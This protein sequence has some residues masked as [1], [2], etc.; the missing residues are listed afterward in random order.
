M[1]TIYPATYYLIVAAGFAWQFM[2]SRSQVR[3][4]WIHESPQSCCILCTMYFIHCKCQ[5]GFP[6]TLRNSWCHIF[7][8][9]PAYLCGHEHVVLNLWNFKN[10]WNTSHSVLETHSCDLVS[11]SDSDSPARAVGRSGLCGLEFSCLPLNVGLTVLFLINSP[12]VYSYPDL[13][14]SILNVITPKALFPERLNIFPAL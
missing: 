11:S 3:A 1:V 9:F 2:L 12:Q 8:L 13:D 10:R 6:L 5:L 14:K 4:W 7:L